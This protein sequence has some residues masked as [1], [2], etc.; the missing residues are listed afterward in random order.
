MNCYIHSDWFLF[1]LGMS[2][3][4][5][6]FFCGLDFSAACLSPSWGSAHVACLPR[7]I[8]CLK[9]NRSQLLHFLYTAVKMNAKSNLCAEL[10]RRASFRLKLGTEPIWEFKVSSLQDSSTE[11]FGKL[12]RRLFY[13]VRS[14]YLNRS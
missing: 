9:I 14:Y 1:L 5:R 4:F 3:N 13:N 12:R 7:P 11:S 10:D 6:P 8:Q 2:E